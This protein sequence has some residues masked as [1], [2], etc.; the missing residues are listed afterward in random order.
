M[1]HNRKGSV[2]VKKAFVSICV[3]GCTSLV[4]AWPDRTGPAGHWIDAGRATSSL[5]ASD[6][7]TTDVNV[8]S[9]YSGWPKNNVMDRSLLTV[10]GS[11]THVSSS[12]NE[13]VSFAFG[14]WKTVN[15]VKFYPRIVNGKAVGS[16]VDFS[17]SYFDGHQWAL[18]RAIANFPAIQHGEWVILPLPSPVLTDGIKISVSKLGDDGV[19]NYVLQMSEIRAGNDPNLSKMRFVSNQG[20]L[21]K[22]QVQGS[23]GSGSFNPSKLSVW[24]RDVRYPLFTADQG[25]DNIYAANVVDNSGVWQVYFGG[26]NNTILHDRIWMKT[27]S[28]DFGT[29]PA[30]TMVFSNGAYYHVNNPSVVKV[31]SNWR[32][33]YTNGN[34]SPF[35]NFTGYA[36]SSNGTSWTPSASSTS[37]LVVIN[38]Y[39][40]AGSDINGSNVI[41]YEGGVYS[42]YFCDW[43]QKISPFCIRYATSTDGV[44]FTYVKA[45][46]NEGR[47]PNDIKS[48][49]YNGTTHYMLLTHFNAGDIRFAVSTDKTAF[50]LSTVLCNS[51][52]SL[53]KYIVSVGAV[54]RGNRLYGVLYGAST[55]S[56]LDDNKIFATW[57]Q[58]KIKF[59]S[60]YEAVGFELAYG[61]DAIQADM[62]AGVNALETGRFY[63]Y[64]SDGTT[65]LY[66]SPQVTIRRGDVW[67][68]EP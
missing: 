18:S 31:G 63:V 13:S 4:F 32:M 9:E 43:Q 22:V 45:A 65:L 28:D 12:G 19:G 57:L 61:P 68:Y 16:P 54:V 51:Y 55:K 49:T 44:N 10:W 24:H 59:I 33:L 53:D 67:S 38:G 14:G 47:V 64:D 27:S 35:G 60:S 40:Q 39:P 2:F 25:G 17:I 56:S 48:F 42:L 7:T 21:A 1:L 6:Y 3:F 58:K 15:Y 8:S 30:A 20:S 41:F 66:T 26:W 62:A 46:Q 36:T 29:L 50:G 52:G 37:C 5:I 34:I 11:D 23:V